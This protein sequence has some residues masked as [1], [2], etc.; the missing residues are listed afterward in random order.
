MT[1][2]SPAADLRRAYRALS[3]T[4]PPA[5][6]HAAAR[7]HRAGAHTHHP[8]PKACHWCL[9]AQR[10]RIRERSLL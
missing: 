4:T 3:R 6:L 7:A 1:T 5:A 10:R 8:L 2:R 9:A